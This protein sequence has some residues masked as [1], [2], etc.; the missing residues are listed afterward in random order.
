MRKSTA[1]ETSLRMRTLSRLRRVFPDIDFQADTNSLDILASREE[2][3]ATR[4]HRIRYETMSDYSFA[5]IAMQVAESFGIADYNLFLANPEGWQNGELEAVTRLREL[6]EE[7]PPRRL[8]CRD[9]EAL[10]F[11]L[12]RLG[13][14][15]KK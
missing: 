7:R 15:S 13:E 11:I 14:K 2:G 12:D 1:Q 8:D 9:R 6:L 4:H 3:N 5:L 10:R